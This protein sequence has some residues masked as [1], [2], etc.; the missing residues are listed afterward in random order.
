[1]GGGLGAPILKDKLFYFGPY[2]SPPGRSAAAARTAFVP[3]A[4]EREGD[5]S[6]TTR[7]LIDPVSK[8][9]IPGNRIPAARLN[10]VSKFFL[11]SIPLPNRG[12]RELHFPARH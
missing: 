11:K 9:P 1:C 12:G 2:Q 10:P 8:Q 7:Q 4:A 5:F 6:S 3:T